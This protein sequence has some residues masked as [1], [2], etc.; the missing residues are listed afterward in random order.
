MFDS[1]GAFPTLGDSDLRRKMLRES[2]RIDSGSLLFIGKDFMHSVR[3]RIFYRALLLCVWCGMQS[4][5]LGAVVFAEEPHA[6]EVGIDTP[7]RTL[8]ELN[9]RRLGVIVGTAHDW[10]TNSSLDFTNLVYY[11]DPALVLEALYAGEID[12]AIDDL[13]V[14]RLLLETS[15]ELSLLPGVLA[16]D[17]YAFAM[18]NDDAATYELIN[19]ALKS[20]QD[21]GELTEVVAKWTELGEEARRMPDIP[22]SESGRVIRF[23]VCP[24]SPPFCY[25]D[26]EGR[27]IG[28]EI[29]LMQR[30]AKRTHFRVQIEPLEFVD[31][32]SSLLNEDIDVIGSCFSVTPERKEIMRF[33]EPIYHGG[34][35]VV[36]LKRPKSLQ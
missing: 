21:N 6:D 20:M 27:T 11:D 23:G 34:V 36:V 2:I 35:S 3:N 9:R 24:I 28:M 5:W 32:V 19:N 15:P 30:I 1:V 17:S 33:S 4:H 31:L 29:E 14:H 26:A 8:D 16:E 12:A 7:I 25:R 18:R 22:A 10:F 13:P